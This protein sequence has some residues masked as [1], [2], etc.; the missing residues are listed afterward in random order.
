MEAIDP[1]RT[2]GSPLGSR[3][4]VGR[5]LSPRRGLLM[6][7][8]RVA[9]FL[10]VASL[11][12]GPAVGNGAFPDSQAV[13]TPE[14]LPHRILLSTNFGEI[15]S[16]DDGRTWTW[17]CEQDINGM[18]NLYQLGP[19]PRHR[20]FARDRGGLVFTDSLGCKWAA[21]T[22]VPADFLLSDAFPDPTNAERVI[23]VAAPRGGT[24]GTYRVLESLD[25]GSTFTNV[26][27]VAASGDTVSG[28]E[29]SRSDSD[30]V[31][32]V[33]LKGAN[34][35]PMLALSTDRGVTWQEHDLSAALGTGSS[36]LLVAVDRVDPQRVFLQ[37]N[38]ASN[39]LAVVDGGGGLV[40]KPLSLDGGFMSGFLQT[41]AG[42]ILVSGLV[43][44]DPVLY[45]SEDGART[46][47]SLPAPPALWGLSQRAGTIFGAARTGASF[48]IGT[49]IDEGS[50]W[51]P[52]MRYA[53]VH[54]VAA[55]AQVA[56]E[57]ACLL[58][59]SLELWSPQIC[60]LD[61]TRDGSPNDIGPSG[62]TENQS[63]CGCSLSGRPS[64]LVLALL[65]PLAIRGMRRRVSRR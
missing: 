44:A 15:T 4:P 8:C 43:G 13:L 50:S 48:A 5:C 11:Q 54:A 65:V 21:P 22:G 49:S 35:D 39:V 60:L 1:P 31:Y 58:Q 28:V 7:R 33:I 62:D 46:F 24:A 3:P 51:Q 14:D 63:G 6:T 42:V 41:E 61:A 32:L 55:C 52:L 25:G 64:P 26:L 29:I 2:P 36:V 37:V 56:C 23:A 27:Y 30:V 17:S 57:D 20:L 18:R 59:A 45:R 9:F 19:A 34:F 12:A 38:A 53:D 10:L 47:A 40:T 16:D